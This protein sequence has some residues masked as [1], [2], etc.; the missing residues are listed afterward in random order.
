MVC[1]LDRKVSIRSVHESM[2]EIEGTAD[3]MGQSQ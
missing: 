2:Q 3:S 1:S